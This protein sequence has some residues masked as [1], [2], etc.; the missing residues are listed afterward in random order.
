MVFFAFAN[1]LKTGNVQGSLFFSRCSR[2]VSADDAE[3]SLKE[4]LSL[5][6]L[7]CTRLKTKFNTY[8]SFHVSAI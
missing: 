8:A 2:K 6:K 7:V 3:K 4:K 1:Y 5:K